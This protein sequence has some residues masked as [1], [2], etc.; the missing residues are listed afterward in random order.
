[1]IPVCLIVGDSIGIGAAVPLAASGAR[2]AVY[3]RVGASSGETV[4]TFHGHA[5]VEHAIISLGSNDAES[6]NLERNLIVVRQRI[7]ARRVTWIVPYHPRASRV[8]AILARSFGDGIVDLGR[9]TSTDG[10]HPVRY[11]DVAKSLNWR[12]APPQIEPQV[13]VRASSTL[14]P[15]LKA[16]IRQATVLRF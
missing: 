11:S 15:A 12:P 3:A 1:M 13:V 7:A 2:C 5:G 10:I 16:S 9:F 8:V 14:R 6:P 4:R